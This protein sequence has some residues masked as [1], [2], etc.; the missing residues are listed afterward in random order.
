MKKLTTKEF[1]NKV[2]LIHGDKYDYSKVKYVKNHNK[3]KI[4]CKKH[5]EFECSSHNHKKGK[6]CAKCNYSSG[7][8][9]INDFL[10]TNNINFKVQYRFNDCR[11]INPLP[12]DFY[13]PDHNIC[14]EF[15]GRQHYEPVKHFGGK[16]ALISTQKRDKIKIGYCLENNTQLLIIKH[17][18]DINEKL[19]ELLNGITTITQNLC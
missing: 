9:K 1:I 16:N 4:I 7:E 2:K 14:I 3:V 5:G 12:F 13:L 10:L 8:R 18:E 15:N 11:S 17:G 6:G 19:N